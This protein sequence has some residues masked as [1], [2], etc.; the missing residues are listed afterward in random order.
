[1]GQCMWG[2]YKNC[3]K[4]AGF[5]SSYLIEEEVPLPIT[6]SQD[7]CNR[8]VSIENIDN[9]NIDFTNFENIVDGVATTGK[10]SDEEIISSIRGKYIIIRSII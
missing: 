4:K 1:M 5:K 2:Y 7:E 9:V 3:L 10:L 6:P 8:V